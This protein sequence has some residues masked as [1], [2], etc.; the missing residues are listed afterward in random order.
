M[1]HIEVTKFAPLKKASRK[2]KK[3]SQKPLMSR[4]LLN[5]VKQKNKLFKQLRNILDEDIFQKYRKQINASNR[6][7]KRAKEN[8]CKD[9]IDYSK[10][11]SSTLWEIIGELANLKKI[12]KHFVIK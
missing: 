6:K 4:E 7:I 12:K 11:N 1:L 5:W 8:Y 10:G 2:E 9:L 3:L